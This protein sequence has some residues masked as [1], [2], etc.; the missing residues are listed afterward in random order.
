M[1]AERVRSIEDGRDRLLMRRHQLRTLIARAEAELAAVEERLDPAAARA[2]RERRRINETQRAYRLRMQAE[3]GDAVGTTS[4]KCGS[5]AG[6]HWHRTHG[7]WPLPADD[8]CGCRAAHAEHV[9]T[10]R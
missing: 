6:Y 8:P 7:P 9:R 2:E 4:E 3:R 5:D 1:S 10:S